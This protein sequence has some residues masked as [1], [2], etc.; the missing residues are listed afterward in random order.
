MS[1]F[2]RPTQHTVDDFRD[3]D[4]K[5]GEEATKETMWMN[6]RDRQTDRNY[7][8]KTERNSTVIWWH[9]P[10]PRL[11]AI[12]VVV[13]NPLYSFHIATCLWLQ[14]LPTM[15]HKYSKY[16]HTEARVMRHRCQLTV[17]LVPCLTI[18]LW[19]THKHNVTAA[20]WTRI[21]LFAI[22]VMFLTR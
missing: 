2:Q 11:N 4:I 5:T 14:Y 15:H 16:W 3:N 6:V 12:V 17:T 8:C 1:K 21:A 13:Q 20:N 18:R 9:L 10:A 19:S 7:N 22:Q